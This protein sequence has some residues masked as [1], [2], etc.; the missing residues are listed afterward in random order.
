MEY[1]KNTDDVKVVTRFPQERPRIDIIEQGLKLFIIESAANSIN[2]ELGGGFAVT[3]SDGSRYFAFYRSFDY[4]IFVAVSS[5]PSMSFTRNVFE[6]LEFED[7]G[8]VPTALLGLAE[9]PIFPAP[10]LQYNVEFSKGATASLKF[11]SLEQAEDV[12]IDLI[13]LSLLSPMM[14]VKAWESII[15][16]RKVLVVST[17]ESV[18]GP[19]CEFLRKMALPL[20]IV[21]TFVPLLP[22]L[23]I[24]TVEAPFPYLLGANTNMLKDSF[25]DLSDTVVVDLDTRSVTQPKN[26][27]ANPVC[28]ASTNMVAK[29]V[30]DINV[31][32]LSPLGGWVN[33]A[34]STSLVLAN[35]GKIEHKNSGPRSDLF[36]TSRSTQILQVFINAN[37][38]LV[39]ARNCAL[40]AFF[41]RPECVSDETYVSLDSVPCKKSLI[42][43][44]FDNRNGVF[45]GYMQLS[46][47]VVVDDD[48]LQHF[49]PTWVE[50]DG[51]VFSVYEYADDLPL[52]YVPNKDLESVSPCPVEPEGHVF[53]LVTKDQT[54]YRFT[55][56][57]MESRRQWIGAIE[58]KMKLELIM[59][60]NNFGITSPISGKSC[61][62]S[63]SNSLLTSSAEENVG[64][65]GNCSSSIIEANAT[66]GLPYP[67]LEETDSDAVVREEAV[68]RYYFMKT[69]M[70]TSL[71]HQVECCEFEAIYKDLDLRMNIT[72]GGQLE[73]DP[74]HSF[75]DKIAPYLWKAGTIISILTKIKDVSEITK[76]DKILSF[77]NVSDHSPRPVSSVENSDQKNSEIVP[78]SQVSRPSS[79]R[80]NIGSSEKTRKGLFG[81]FHRNSR[82]DSKSDTKDELSTSVEQ[83]QAAQRLREKATEDKMTQTI[84]AKIFLIISSYKRCQVE[85]Q[86]SI[87]EV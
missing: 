33:R 17:V 76:T 1:L 25:V 72:S 20:V 61:D 60:L 57:D 70:L 63:D 71:L 27:D 44:G 83:E 31:I 5:F 79:V 66:M 4:R 22:L 13:A 77:Q 52:I 3:T 51:C 53:E 82:V 50:M 46:K 54:T 28:F 69:Q 87:V 19:C 6:L 18:I 32:I 26:R 80:S 9:I 59:G 81:L 23:L 7:V 48:I 42:N 39:S 47:G 37:L 34:S 86:K 67:S 21:N 73:E 35:G 11:S 24:N 16:E 14:L 68:F 2:F 56:T 43:M 8:T 12:D 62:Q 84:R 38:S 36:F 65:V 15:L 78:S 75:D 10:G 49:V 41:R 58:E 30:Q 45:S 64:A 55:A 40:R 85:L 29:L 74:L